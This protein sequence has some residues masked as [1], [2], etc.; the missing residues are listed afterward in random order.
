MA[1]AGETTQLIRKIRQGDPQAREE[2][3]DRLY[4]ELHRR[5]ERYCRSERK[6][7]TLSPS[8]LIH[9][10]Y[11]ALTE[12]PDKDWQ[13]RAHFIAVASKA[14]RHILVDY[15]RSHRADKRAG[16]HQQISFNEEF[17]L[18]P[19]RAEQ[20]LALDEALARLE[21]LDPRQSRIVELRFFG[22]LSEKETAEV[23]SIGVRTVTREWSMAKAWLHGELKSPSRTR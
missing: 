3:W 5:A 15:A 10:A 18:A 1:A 20:M 17:V 6:G 21:Q 8:G 16:A 12:Q 19:E 7:H 22:G 23:L 14:M 13:N 2:L 4:P 11:F 9:E